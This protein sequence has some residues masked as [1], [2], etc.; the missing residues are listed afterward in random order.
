MRPVCHQGRL[1]AFVLHEAVLIITPNPVSPIIMSENENMP[2]GYKPVGG[3][4]PAPASN[5]D[6]KTLELWLKEQVYG[7][8]ERAH[9]EMSDAAFH[10]N[11]VPLP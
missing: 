10:C 5:H 11:M 1:F 7:C 9:V 4:A 8:V 2:H 3:F 6:R